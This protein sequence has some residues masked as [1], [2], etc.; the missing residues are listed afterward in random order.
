MT[1]PQ[2]R[3]EAALDLAARGFFIFALKPGAKEPVPGVS[4][5]ADKTRDPEKIRNIFVSVPNANYGVCPGPHGVIID[6]D[7]PTAK[8]PDKADGELAL[9][10]LESEQDISDWIS[11]N[12]YQVHTP[13]GGRHI[14]LRTDK[15]LGNAHDLPAGIDV[16]G[17]AGYVVGPECEII[18]GMCEALDTPGAYTVG[19]AEPPKKIPGW[20]LFKI[21]EKRRKKDDQSAIVELDTDA[22]V[23]RA[24]EYLAFAEPA[25]Q[26]H[27]G[28]DHTF[29]VACK[30]R[31]LGISF[32]KCVELMTE[33]GGWNERCAPAWTVE[34]LSSGPAGNAFKYAQN[35]QGDKALAWDLHSDADSNPSNLDAFLASGEGLSEEESIEERFKFLKS[36]TKSAQ[37]VLDAPLNTDMVIPDWLPVKG[38]VGLIAKRGSGKSTLLTDMAM[39]IACDMNWHNI[40]IMED[41]AVVYIAGEDADGASKMFK[42]WMKQHDRVPDYRRMFVMEQTMSLMS[43]EQC[44]LWSE[45]FKWLFQGRRVVI[46]GDTWQRA[47]AEASQ[48]DDK[49]MST[50]IS[51]LE[52]MARIM[53][54]PAVMACHPPKDDSTTI[55][56]SGLMENTSSALWLID[57]TYTSGTKLICTRIKGAASGSWAAFKHHNVP[58]G[59]TDRFGREMTGRIPNKIS[60]SEEPLSDAMLQMNAAIRHAYAK[61]ILELLCEAE[62]KDP[63]NFS[64]NRDRFFTM[65]DTANRIAIEHS[66]RLKELR[67]AGETGELK[68]SHLTARLTEMFRSNSTPEILDN[69]V[70][71][72]FGTKTFE[73]G[74]TTVDIPTSLQ[75]PEAGMTDIEEPILDI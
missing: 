36:I 31:E 41:W 65:K 24:R 11:I 49:E 73:H 8:K 67:D 63:E 48:I 53:R 35:A 51:N 13:S 74:R 26:G 56:G 58:L 66:S 71:L 19:V 20:I 21:G 7:K 52:A 18:E 68:A 60:G 37:E 61:L 5:S 54:G 75:E 9:N 4:W 28:N 10:G 22:A 40:P 38:F 70:S 39:R 44:M 50:A 62:D 17:A 16:R 2:A 69:G 32:E 14:Y 45:Y 25:I 12:G 46:F 30:V 23:E 6:L 42:G 27:N 55:M 34:E 43:V 64:K 59:V 72:V 1:A 47:T 33:D 29:K 15:P 3:V 57:P